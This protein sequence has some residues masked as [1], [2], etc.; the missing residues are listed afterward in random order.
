MMRLI[1]IVSNKK[2]KIPDKCGNFCPYFGEPKDMTSPCFRCPIMNCTVIN[3]ISM[4]DAEKFSP[5]ITQE[6]IEWWGLER[7]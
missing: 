7:K 3:G 4:C 1:L 2:L 5:I 6:Y